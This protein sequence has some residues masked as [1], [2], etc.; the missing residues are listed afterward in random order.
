[1]SSFTVF[2]SAP[3]HARALSTL[4][5][6][7]LVLCVSC[8]V[9]LALALLPS[10]AWLAMVLNWISATKSYTFGFVAFVFRGLCALA[11]KDIFNS[12][13]N[14]VHA[15]ARDAWNQWSLAP[16]TKPS[17]SSATATA[18]ATAN[19][20]TTE[21]ATP[22]R[23]SRLWTATAL[24]WP[25][26]PIALAL[27]CLAH[28][29]LLFF[30][31]GVIFAYVSNYAAE[32]VARRLY[33]GMKTRMANAWHRGVAIMTALTCGVAACASRAVAAARSMLCVAN[34][35]ERRRLCVDETV[36]QPAA[37]STAANTTTSTRTSTSTT[38]PPTTLITVRKY[39]IQI[40]H[41]VVLYLSSKSRIVCAA[42]MRMLV[43][44]IVSPLRRGG[45]SRVSNA[46]DKNDTN[47]IRGSAF[48]ISIDVDMDADADADTLH[49]DMDMGVDS[50]ITS[51]DPSQRA[52]MESQ[53]YD[54]SASISISTS[55]TSIS[56]T[57]ATTSSRSGSAFLAIT[58]ADNDNDESLPPRSTLAS[59]WIAM[60]RWSPIGG[61]GHA[62]WCRSASDCDCDY[63]CDL[64][65][66]LELDCGCDSDGD[67]DK[68]T[69]SDTASDTDID[70][71]TDPASESCKC[72]EDA[73]E[74]V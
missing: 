53:V 5:L 30:S 65:C 8:A 42:I 56:A 17:A 58:I 59:P 16:E 67:N 15:T 62:T 69:A 9:A 61:L 28:V 40:V 11:G 31:A 29:A 13:Y 4:A 66:D 22:S 49:M 44:W 64:C 57:S 14:A 73:F 21:T 1:M 47:D 72:H 6:C 7:A 46:T 32:H 52:D 63:D 10:P 25:V 34:V 20:T 43:R 27:T 55:A 33:P 24:L 48:S 2:F 38:S 26:V 60:K 70:T 39:V 19:A 54:G 3:L 23:S 74:Q 50:D 37:P 41:G 45:S 35:L 12:V 68:D 51:F 36:Q 71:E 18:T